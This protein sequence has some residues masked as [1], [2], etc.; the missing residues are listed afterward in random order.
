MGKG[1][2]QEAAIRAF[3]NIGIIAHIDAGKTTLTERILYYT[4]KI[5]R[6]G[7]VHEGTATMDFMPEEQERGITITSACTS[8]LWRDKQINIIDT[9][10]HVDFTIEVERSLRVLDGAVG[11]FCAVGGVEPQSETVWRQS[12]HYHVPKLAFI[13]KMDRLGADFFAVIE[14]MRQKLQANPVV[15]QLPEGAGSEFTGVIDILGGEFLRFDPESKG[16]EFERLALSEEQAARAETWRD[17][18][19]ESVAEFD[20]GLLERYLA[21]EPISDAEIREALRT[22]TLEQRAVPVFAGSALKNIGVQ[23]ILD[24]ICDFLPSPLEVPPAEGIDPKTQKKKSFPVSPTSPLAALVFK[25]SLEGGRLLSMLRIYSGSIKAGEQV[26][27]ATQQTTQR[28]ARLFTMHAGHKDRLDEAGAGQIVAVAGL[29]NGRTGDTLCRAADPIIL[30]QISAYKPVISLALEPRN[31]PEEEK[32]LEALEKMLQEDP[33]LSLTRDDDTEQIIL[34]GM[35]ELHLEIVLER[36]KREY[37]VDLRAGKP[38]VVYRETLG[39]RAAAE[40]EFARELGE[41]FH[42]GFVALSVEPANR[43]RDNSIVFECDTTQL[44]EKWV[45]AVYQGLEDGLQS[46]ILRGY[47]VQGVT[48]RVLRMG[49][50]GDRTSEVGY[51]LAAG[52]ALKK[53]MAEADPLLMEPIMSLEVL[54]PEDFVGEVVSLVGTK[55]GK[56]ENMY[57]RGG[58]KVVQALAPLSHLFGFS[59]D[60]RSATQGRGNFMMRFERFDVLER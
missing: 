36:L 53:A 46:G 37:K 32:L 50:S 23:P 38:Q 20:D 25:V 60:L 17:K 30:E 28:V 39:S 43:S 14:D 22:A 59:T 54:V 57:D 55:G 9:P 33:T 40:E 8:C 58:G 34:S 3:R 56:I 7:E 41:A 4:K 10:G 18:L 35:G 31:A 51:H 27:N 12:E 42:Y 45:Q 6:L 11:V 1:R 49:T 2:G 48:V 19:V 26:Y 21:G 47:P 29:K 15:L 44:D 5:H 13:N 24:A 52:A 16:M